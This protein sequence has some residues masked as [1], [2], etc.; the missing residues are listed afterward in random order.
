MAQDKSPANRRRAAVLS[1]EDQIKDHDPET[2]LIAARVMNLQAETKWDMPVKSGKPLKG[3][4]LQEWLLSKENQAAQATVERGIGFALLKREL[5][6][7]AFE[8]WLKDKGI[9]PRSARE[10]MQAA[11]LLMS[12]SDTNVKR[13]ALLPARKLSVLAG[14]PAELVDDLF[15]SGSLDSI[16]QMAREQLREIVQLRKEV[17]KMSAR[18]DRLN[19][20]ITEQDDELRQMRGLPKVRAHILE[21][22]R[23]VLE[24]T[25][26]VR[27]NI[28]QLQLILDRVAM[29]PSDVNR[30]DLDSITHPLMWAIQGAQATIISIYNRAFEIIEGLPTDIDVFPPMLAAPEMDRL[31]RCT[32]EFM[33]Q[34]ELRMAT[35]QVEVAAATGIKQKRGPKPKGKK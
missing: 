21:M 2:Q 26:A 13:A 33:S 19:Q 9:S 30:S 25:A 7:G 10:A 27:T 5:G 35:R 31:R 18:E 23:A 6:H 3:E 11:R 12:L 29:L 16:E 20:T 17:E 15:N 14:A 24:E 34:A 22:R 28:H 4:A 8:G 1:S 32:A